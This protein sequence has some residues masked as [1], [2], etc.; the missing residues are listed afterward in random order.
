MT[1]KTNVTVLPPSGRKV[2]TPWLGDDVMKALEE[3]AAQHGV[4]FSMA[5]SKVTATEATFYVRAA[6]VNDDAA[7]AE[8]ARNCGVAGL[9]PT[10]FKRKFLYRGQLYTILKAMPGRVKYP[11]DVERADGKR[12]KFFGQTAYTK[13]QWVS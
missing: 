2:I 4:I 1:T 5:K 11:L 6:L 8:F 10:D 9:E 7:R 3:V 12:F 13:F